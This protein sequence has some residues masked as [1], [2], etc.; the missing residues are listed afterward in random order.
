VR[1]QRRQEGT[2]SYLILGGKAA[3]D[4]LL[5]SREAPAQVIEDGPA[6]VGSD[7]EAGPAVAGVLA[8]LDQVGLD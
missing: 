4:V 5:G 7:D 8:A 3:E 2:E 6:V 1:G